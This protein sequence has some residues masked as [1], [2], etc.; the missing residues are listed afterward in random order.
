M[1]AWRQ[2]NQDRRL[3]VG[4]RSRA[5]QKGLPISI[6]VDDIQIPEFCPVLGLRL[7]M[8]VGTQTIASPSLDRIIPELGYVPGNVQVIS[9]LANSMKNNATPE[10]L[11]A[12]AAWVMREH[13]K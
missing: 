7:E 6:T 4:A 5:K 12:F 2:A 10:Q 8:G 11:L 1:T 9:Y 3:L 13:G